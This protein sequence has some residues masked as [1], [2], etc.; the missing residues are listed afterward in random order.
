MKITQKDLSIGKRIKKFR[1][2]L[3]L[4][5]EQLADKVRISTTHI[6]LVETGYRRMS[7]KTLQ[8]VATALKVKVKDLITF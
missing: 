7:M 2:E 4:T 6:G 3:N 5:Q 8:K 1:R